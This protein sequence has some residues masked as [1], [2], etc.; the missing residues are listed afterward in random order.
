MELTYIKVRRPNKSYVYIL[1]YARGSQIHFEKPF[2]NISD[3]YPGLRFTSFA[4]S[5]RGFLRTFPD[6]L[7]SCADTDLDR[8]LKENN[9][10][11]REPD[12]VEK[13]LYENEWV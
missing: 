8:W 1:S 13:L 4:D 10:T 6:F 9:F 12:K 2:N 7:E 11:L 5:V 3:T